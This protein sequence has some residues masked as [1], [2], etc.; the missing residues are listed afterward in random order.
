MCVVVVKQRYVTRLQALLPDPL[1]QRTG[2][3]LTIVA[4]RLAPMNQAV[5]PAGN[6]QQRCRPDTTAGRANQVRVASSELPQDG[7]AGKQL[8]RELIPS[9]SR[10]LAVGKSMR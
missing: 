8:A 2:P 6:A 5:A 3:V 1:Q 10:Q 9:E 7:P 4:V